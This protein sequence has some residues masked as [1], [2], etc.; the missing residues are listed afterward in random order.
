MFPGPTGLL[1]K[2]PVQEQRS[3]ATDD[4]VVHVG[5]D[6][7]DALPPQGLELHR[8]PVR[9]A[10]QT[11][12]EPARE[13]RAEPVGDR[14]HVGFGNQRLRAGDNACPSFRAVH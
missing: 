9:R 4:L 7:H 13:G 10:P 1:H 8:Q 11:E 6:H 2:G 14:L 5:C 3:A 12:Q